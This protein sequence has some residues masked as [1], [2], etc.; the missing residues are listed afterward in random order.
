MS[1]K[2]SSGIIHLLPLLVVGGIIVLGLSFVSFKGNSS[3]PTVLS[4]NKEIIEVKVEDKED[5]QKDE[6]HG[7]QEKEQ[8]QEKE[9]KEIKVKLEKT[10]TDDKFE[11]RLAEQEGEHSE[12]EAEFENSSGAGKIK[13]KNENSKFVLEYEGVEA[14]SKYP[15]SI[16][17]DTGEL[18]ISTPA[19]IKVVTVLPDQAVAN[20]LRKKKI[21]VITS[22]E[23]KDEEEASGSGEVNEGTESGTP[24]ETTGGVV[25]EI[26]GEEQQQLFGTFN[27]KVKKRY[28][29]SAETGQLV[30][31][32]TVTFWDRILDLLSS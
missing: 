15:L 11:Y 10:K 32:E 30:L 2:Y 20:M 24:G 5:E 27:V 16:N 21:N 3:E 12:L 14:D 1:K 6:D 8:E 28:Q 9:K 26:Q 25:Y 7:D 18:I 22:V 31:E 23:I 4:D 13:I 29:I 17:P 19:G